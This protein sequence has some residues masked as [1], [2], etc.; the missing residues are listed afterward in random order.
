MPDE[1]GCLYSVP[2]SGKITEWSINLNDAPGAGESYKFTLRNNQVNQSTSD[3]V[4]SGTN[5][6][7]SVT[8]ISINYNSGENLSVVA[9]GS[10]S[11]TKTELTWSALFNIL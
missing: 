6:T 11:S 8:S 7:G 1:Y 3:L 10:S 9:T 2:I 4:I 5:R